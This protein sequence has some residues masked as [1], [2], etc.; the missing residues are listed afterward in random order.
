MSIV[1][2]PAHSYCWIINF[3][4]Y[5]LACRCASVVYT[6]MCT[7]AQCLST[8]GCYDNADVMLTLESTLVVCLNFKQTTQSQSSRLLTCLRA[9]RACRHARIEAL[10][11]FLE[12]ELGPTTFL[13]VRSLYSIV[14]VARFSGLPL[15]ELARDSARIK[16]NHPS[17]L[18]TKHALVHS[19]KIFADGECELRRCITL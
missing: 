3:G 13:K 16:C 8:N 14:S 9:C 4:I 19:F 12:K 1:I 10:R 6:R 7:C 15:L 11:V 17:F 5:R 2:S 18:H